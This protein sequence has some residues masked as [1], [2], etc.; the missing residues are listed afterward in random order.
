MPE[1]RGQAFAADLPAA[2]ED[3]GVEGDDL[4]LTEAAPRPADVAHDDA[5]ATAGDEDAE[6]LLPDLVELLE[7]TL[8]VV[9]MAQLP[10]A[11]S[12]LDEVEVGRRG[13]HQVDRLVLDGSHV[14]GIPEDDAVAG[15]EVVALENSAVDLKLVR[16]RGLAAIDVQDPDLG[17]PTHLVQG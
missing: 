1:D 3:V 6:A 16:D 13:D 10:R 4:V 15:L 17:R 9:N 8:V 2:D 5:E 7:E 12:V 14:S 11:I